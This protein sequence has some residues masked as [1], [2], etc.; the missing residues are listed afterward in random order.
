MSRPILHGSA[1]TEIPSSITDLSSLV[2]G[3]ANA[4]KIKIITAESCTA[5]AL[6]T[7]L[8]DTPGAG[9]VL[10]GGIVTYSK[11]CKS[12]ILGVDPALLAKS[13][14]TA[15]VAIAMAKGAIARCPSANLAISVTCVGGPTPDEDGNPVGLAFLAASDRKGWTAH[16]RLMIDYQSS[17]KIR[18]EVLTQALLLLLHTMEQTKPEHNALKEPHK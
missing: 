4:R 9:D 18:G 2:I 11:S 1:M 15:E 14:V 3:T 7:L 8:A 13:A 12:D 16:K 6:T 5:G 17:G 10:I